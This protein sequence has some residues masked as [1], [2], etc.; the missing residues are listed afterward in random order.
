[1]EI[2]EAI[3]L[4]LDGECTLFL[5]AG[6]SLGCR[7]QDGKPLPTGRDLAAE[8]R[9]DL[10]DYPDDVAE[11]EDDLADL[12]DL[13]EDL[14][15]ADRLR[16]KL[17]RRFSVSS[18]SVPQRE[19]ARIP[20]R[21]VYTTNFD[22]AFEVASKQ[23][24][25]LTRGVTPSDDLRGLVSSERACIHLHGRV[26]DSGE[27]TV[28]DQLRLSQKAYAGT[29]VTDRPFAALFRR[30]MRQS[31]AVFF[32][33]YSL[34]DLDIERVM[35]ELDAPNE[36][37]FFVVGPAP[38]RKTVRKCTRFGSVV[39]QS[40]ETF[41]VDVAAAR[42]AHAQF[43]R[44]ERV[45]LSLSLWPTPPTDTREATDDDIAQLL[46]YG[47][48][49]SGLV[50]HAVADGNSAYLIPRTAL[51]AVVESFRGK[52]RFC[53]V[54]SDIGNGKTI[55]AESVSA[56]LTQRGWKVYWA[57]D[58][59]NETLSEIDAVGATGQD[60][61]VV[62]D[63]YRSWTPHLEGLLEGLPA[64]VRLLFTE[65]SAVHDARALDLNRTLERFG[66][67]AE[68]SLDYLD[69]SE[70]QAVTGRLAA[71]G[72]WGEM[73]AQ[74]ASRLFDYVVHDCD[75]QL[76][77]VLLNV[78]ES[79][80]IR[81][82]LH[83][84]AKALGT[85]GELTDAIVTL[86]IF[87]VLGLS[88]SP[89]VLADVWD[90]RALTSG[91]LAKVPSLQALVKVER[92]QFSLRSPLTARHILREIEDG[93]RLGLLLLK[94]ART[95]HDMRNVSRQHWEA[96]TLLHRFSTLQKVLPQHRQMEECIRFYERAKAFPASGGDPLFWL[97]YAIAMLFHGELDRS[98]KYFNT[99]YALAK[100]RGMNT[101]QIDNHYARYRLELAIATSNTERAYEQYVH[102]RAHIVLEMRGVAN[103]HY[104][105]RVAARIGEF[106]ERHRSNLSDSQ[107]ND[108]VGTAREVLERVGRLEERLRAHPDVRR[109]VDA[110]RGV[111]GNAP[112]YDLMSRG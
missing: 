27:A 80:T 58:S 93:K 49:D 69:D 86:L 23:V 45:W 94:L 51:V 22:D 24:Q 29:S 90:A 59:D 111:A 74:H 16:T 89:G 9:A 52:T 48:A 46:L 109:C 2:R 38:L 72:L 21:R 37:T 10:V 103:R 53:V 3:H 88:M 100:K 31:R 20:W 56:A 77:L 7:D 73:A 42:E 39:K 15:G 17:T 1:M 43:P 81:E 11:V 62:V 44:A 106:W 55:F 33:G 91:S 82:R 34:D 4:A 87:R 50:H 25:V 76:H 97:Q 70:V 107:R 84:I 60:A 95:F 110:L 14:L 12:A 61:L 67:I 68:Y 47:A 64:T 13:Y 57:N 19:I 8:L 54:T 71:Q 30:D 40:T 99:A 83:Q 112:A 92:G 28:V 75:R 79:P 104:P 78:L 18:V 41:A 6:F 35:T 36:R 26:G 32:V 98:G 101:F 102:A 96:Y 65:R 66:A 5:G 85:P 105:Y 108:V 63:G